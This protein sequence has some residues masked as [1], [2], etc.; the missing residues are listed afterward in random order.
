MSLELLSWRRELLGLYSAGRHAPDPAAGHQIWR[1]ERDILLK[2]HPVSPIPV[3]LRSSYPGADV[4]P[5]DPAYRFLCRV[6]AAEPQRL[7]LQTTTDGLVPFERIG[8]VELDG[9]GSLDVWW[10]GSYGGG[11]FIPFRDRAAR[12]CG[13]GR[14]LVDTVKGAGLG[15]DAEALVVDLN[16][17]YQPSCAYDE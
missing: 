9:L 13:G 10:L 7:E 11:L 8:R 3:Q 4:M 6:L 5:Y 17:A 2:T 1:E 15:G 16:F 14:Y 12:S